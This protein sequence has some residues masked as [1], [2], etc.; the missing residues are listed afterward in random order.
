VK[1]ILFPTEFSAHAPEM[2]RFALALAQA[3]QAEI[4]VM[5][6]FGLPEPLVTNVDDETREKRVLEK[7]K[8]F[9]QKNTPEA[10]TQVRVEHLPVL[11]YPA[12]AI[13]EQAKKRKADLIVLGMTGKTNKLEP[14]LGSTALR[15][16]RAA[17]V[18]V[19]AI[20]ATAVYSPIE[21]VTFTTNFVFDDLK[22]INRLL[23]F[24]QAEIHVLHVVDKEREKG[25]ALENLATLSETYQQRGNLRF[26]LLEHSD[27]ELAIEEYV[28]EIN[29]GLL[30]MTS[31]KKN[32]IN[33][34]L[35]GSTSRNIARR[36]KTPLLVYKF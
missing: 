33:L 9:T 7:L 11:D 34:L 24:F 18:P 20:P 19:L 13:L 30:A 28:N 25:L 16:L 31:H 26:K 10:F 23:A 36:T 17:D 6:A 14:F 29:A 5:H 22:V 32:V 35:E 2:Y 27:V 12:E 1:K 3:H 4:I 15:V 21:K 8:Q